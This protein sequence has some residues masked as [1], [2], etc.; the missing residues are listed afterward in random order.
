MYVIMAGLVEE[1]FEVTHDGIGPLPA[2]PDPARLGDLDPALTG[3]AHPVVHIYAKR[4]LGW[5]EGG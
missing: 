2:F 3:S 4:E 1:D 5:R